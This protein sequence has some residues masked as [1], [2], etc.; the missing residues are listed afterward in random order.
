MISTN[1]QSHNLR[2]QEKK[3]TE[4]KQNK[5]NYLLLQIINNN[6]ENKG[7]ENVRLWQADRLLG[8]E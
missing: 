1:L 5:T 6:N 8:S 2:S 4:I 3:K 7:N